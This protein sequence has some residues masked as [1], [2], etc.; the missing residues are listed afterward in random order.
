MKYLK[1]YAVLLLA[2]L[3]LGGCA[4]T[5]QPAGQGL[6]VVCTLFPQYDFARAVAGE[7]AQVTLL[8]PP[9]V[10]SHSYEPS[11]QDIIA[12]HNADVFLYTGQYMEPWAQRITA[13]LPASV[14]VADVSAGLTLDA[15]EDDD[16]EEEED[17]SDH[18]HAFD[19]H[20]WTDPTMA[21][22]MVQNIAA[23]LQAADP[24]NA[25]VYGANAAAYIAKLNALDADIQ[26]AVSKGARRTICFGG[27]FALHYFAKRYGLTYIAAYDS[28]SSE[29]EPSARAVARILDTIRAERIPVIY[30]EE[31]VEPKV[32][33]AIAAET[34]VTPLLLHS[35]HNLSAED[36]RGGVT[37]LALM[38]QNLANLKA[39]LA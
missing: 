4:Q 35:C 6:R 36:M 3:M 17:E 28:C 33:N 32:A 23:A 38:Y 8:L 14:R 10:E 9:G 18:A 21:A 29:T 7:L 5:P 27:R 1:R 25:G 34:G 2:C 26:A 22:V 15:E 20:I 19:P 13:A 24:Q 30:Y 11:P 16:E 12:I 37:Y 39:G 31:L